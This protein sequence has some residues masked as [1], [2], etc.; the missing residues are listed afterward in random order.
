MLAFNNVFVMRHKAK[1][2]LMIAQHTRRTLGR[3]SVV[4]DY[5]N[6]Q[7]C[8]TRM[9]IL[10]LRVGD[11]PCKLAQVTVSGHERTCIS[12]LATF[13]DTSECGNY[14]AGNVQWPNTYYCRSGKSDQLRARETIR[15]ANVRYEDLLWSSYS[16][17]SPIL[18]LI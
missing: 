4:A 14:F 15:S 16:F 1:C 5:S 7:H 8:T 12:Q 17:F 13:D 3:P 18:D 2:S 10:L 9:D 6:D 11:A